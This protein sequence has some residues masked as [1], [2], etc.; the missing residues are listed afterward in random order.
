TEKSKHRD[1]PAAQKDIRA[2][3]VGQRFPTE[4]LKLRLE[5]RAGKLTKCS[6]ARFVFLQRVNEFKYTENLVPDGKGL[7]AFER[8]DEIE[9][10]GGRRAVCFHHCPRVVQKIEP[11]CRG[12]GVDVVAKFLQECGIIQGAI[13]P[14]VAGVGLQDIRAILK[15]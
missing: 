5:M 8:L 13:V 1:E 15:R 7:L 4:T 3:L 11:V 10:I 2:R 9:V 6:A 14:G 12:Q